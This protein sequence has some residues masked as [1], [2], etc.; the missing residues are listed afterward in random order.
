MPVIDGPRLGRPDA[1]AEVIRRNNAASRAGSRLVI[2]AGLSDEARQ[3]LGK[4][5]PQKWIRR[6]SVTADLANLQCEFFPKSPPVRWG[7]D[8][9]GLGLL[10]ALYAST[11]IVFTEEV[12]PREA[13]SSKSGHL[14]VCEG[15]NDLSQVIA[16][17]Y[18]YALRGGLCIVPEIAEDRSEELLERLYSLYDDQ[19]ASPTESL[20]HIKHQLRDLCGPLAIPPGGSV[21]FVTDR[22]PYGFAFSEAPSTHLFKYPDLGISI[23]NGFAA[24]QPDTTGVLVAAL[25]DPKTTDAPEIDAATRRLP[26][27][28]IFVRRYCGPGADVRSI[29][30]M[31]ELFP[32]DLLLIATHCGDAPG[33]R[34]T[35]E[36]EDSEGI[37]RELVVDI[38]IGIARTDEAELLNV[39]Q[40]MRF[41]S[42]DGVN[43]RDPA[44]S[45]KLY[46]G[47][48]IRDFMEKTARRQELEPVKRETIPR[49]AGSAV[50]SELAPV[51]T[52]Q[53]A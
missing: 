42:L 34:W 50:L 46:V 2:F 13:V 24:E 23:I 3:A 29:S 41:Q 43:W 21:T 35:Y 1:Q 17:N 40:Y 25:V 31:V 14:V 16:A 32:Y 12:S 4:Y 9:I 53:S 7:R 52:G 8:R 44:K 36:F 38:A 47:T 33:Y 49:V 11:D 18:A 22:L 28:G 6:V 26:P 39:T 20:G 45:E 27:R 15:G 37:H 51:S 5:I 19:T 48:A 10:T 30:R